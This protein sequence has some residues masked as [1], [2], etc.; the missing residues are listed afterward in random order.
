MTHVTRLVQF[1]LPSPVSHQFRLKRIYDHVLFWLLS[2]VS[3]SVS[4]YRCVQILSCL[5]PTGLSLRLVFFYGISNVPR[6]SIPC[7]YHVTVVPKPLKRD[8]SVVYLTAG[9]LFIGIF[10]N[11][12]IYLTCHIHF[13][14]TFNLWPIQKLNSFDPAW[15]F[16]HADHLATSSR[17]TLFYSLPKF[18]VTPYSC[19]HTLFL[20]YQVIFS[21]LSSNV[22]IPRWFL[23]STSIISLLKLVSGHSFQWPL[24]FTSFG[25]FCRTLR[26]H[27]ITPCPFP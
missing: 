14:W 26:H 12:K 6:L 20:R 9:S 10:L 24:S 3:I 27:R 11:M 5:L 8:C 19:R 18:H 1:V 13:I 4:H 15:K 17:D 2:V 7:R 22:T 23:L 21:L 16:R 25:Y